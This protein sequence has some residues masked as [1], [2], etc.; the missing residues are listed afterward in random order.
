MNKFL[1]SY[2]FFFLLIVNLKIT[3]SAYTTTHVL[4][5]E[6]ISPES[7]EAIRNAVRTKNTRAVAVI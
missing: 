2:L 3:G 6:G 5:F 1:I 7:L 4:S